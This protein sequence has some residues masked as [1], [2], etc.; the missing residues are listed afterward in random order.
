M[1]A[2]ALATVAGML[3]NPSATPLASADDCPAAEVVFARGTNE[4]PG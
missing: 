2:A 1:G 4:P 3:A